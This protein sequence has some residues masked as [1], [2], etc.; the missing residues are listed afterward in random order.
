MP[1]TNPSIGEF[2]GEATRLISVIDAGSVQWKI[3]LI[4]KYCSVF[5]AEAF[6]EQF[7]P[8][9]VTLTD[10]ILIHKLAEASR[11]LEAKGWP[12][13]RGFNMRFHFTTCEAFV[14]FA[15]QRDLSTSKLLTCIDYAK[16]Y[17]LAQIADQYGH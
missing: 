11:S 7:G 15:H 17:Y 3:G 14:W 8:I 12:R 9:Q 10:T 16:K 13:V 5:A 1:S 6:I 2:I 4:E